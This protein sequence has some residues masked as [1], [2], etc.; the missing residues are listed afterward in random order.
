MPRISDVS[1]VQR[2]SSA[3]GMTQNKT[4]NAITNTT[5]SLK[6]SKVESAPCELEKLSV[7]NQVL[8][9]CVSL[10]SKQPRY[11]KLHP[12]GLERSTKKGIAVRSGCRIEHQPTGYT[13]RRINECDSSETASLC[14]L[15]SL[16]FCHLGKVY[17]CRL[18]YIEKQF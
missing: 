17:K 15:L 13:H 14:C 11:K 2:P 5:E 12:G 7:A 4:E 9:Q 8:H 16:T 10:R 1:G 6:S 3:L 18:F